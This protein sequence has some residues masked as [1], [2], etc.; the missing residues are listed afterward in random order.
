MLIIAKV[1]Y[2]TEDL[3]FLCGQK[4]YIM[5]LFQPHFVL[6]EK[7]SDKCLK[8]LYDKILEIR[9]SKFVSILSFFNILYTLVLSQYNSFAS[10][11]TERLCPF[12]SASI[13]EPICNIKRRN[14]PQ[15]IS[16]LWYRQVTLNKNKHGRFTPQRKPPS[17][18][19]CSF[20]LAVFRQK[21]KQK[22]C[23][24]NKYYVLISFYNVF[25]YFW[26]QSY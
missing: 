14:Q 2:F 23:I 16:Y 19:L 3:F 24:S 4:G 22:V 17:L 5:L 13:F 7:S 18:I 8:K 9:Y 20:K 12:S 21:N 26:L 25:K 11:C 6:F 1:M 10:H 15:P